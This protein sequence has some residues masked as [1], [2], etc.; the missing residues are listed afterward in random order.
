M[1]P[2]WRLPTTGVRLMGWPVLPSPLVSCRWFHAR[3]NLLLHDAAKLATA[4]ALVHEEQ[5]LSG[6]LHRRLEQRIAPLGPYLGRRDVRMGQAIPD[7]T[8]AQRVALLTETDK[9]VVDALHALADTITG[10]VH[11]RTAR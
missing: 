1:R 4:A 6:R 10:I 2:V 7:L 9:H 3:S 5:R 11:V 8:H